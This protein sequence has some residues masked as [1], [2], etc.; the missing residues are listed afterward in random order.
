VPYGYEQMVRVSGRPRGQSQRTYIEWRYGMRFPEHNRLSREIHT[1]VHGPVTPPTTPSPTS[2]PPAPR[3]P[4]PDKDDDEDDN[5][6]TL[7]PMGNKRGADGSPT[8]APAKRNKTSKS[9]NT[10][11]SN[12]AGSTSRHHVQ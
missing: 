1:A 3:K 8:R 2:P 7:P 4:R 11:S 5:G 12:T 10:L 9:E 6:G